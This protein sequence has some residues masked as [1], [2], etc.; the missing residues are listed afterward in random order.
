VKNEK[1]SS[2]LQ[3]FRF[4]ESFSSSGFLVQLAFYLVRNKVAGNGK[5]NQITFRYNVSF[6]LEVKNERVKNLLKGAKENS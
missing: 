3:R 1:L 5:N 6:I 2:N 4:L